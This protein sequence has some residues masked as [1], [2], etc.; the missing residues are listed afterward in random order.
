MDDVTKPTAAKPVID[1]DNLPIHPLA[2]EWPM[3]DNAE[4]ES[5]VRLDQGTRHPSADHHL[6]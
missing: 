6:S 1:Y 5:N 2:D 3:A 4:L